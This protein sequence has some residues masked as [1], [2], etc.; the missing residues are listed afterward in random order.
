[1]LT[2]Y[3][4]V[5]A[6]VLCLVLLVAATGCKKEGDYVVYPTNTPPTVSAIPGQAADEDVAFSLDVSAFVCDAEDDVAD[7]AFTVLSGGGSFTGAVYGNTFTAAGTVSV[8]FAVADT[9]GAM[10]MGSFNVTIDPATYPPLEITTESLP[11]ATAMR[12]YSQQLAAQGGLAPYVWQIAG[13]S[14]PA[15]LTLSSS[16]LIS[17]IPLQ[18]GNH[19]FTVRCIDSKGT[20]VFRAFSIDVKHMWV[21]MPGSRPGVDYPIPRFGHAMAYDSARGVVVLFGGCDYNSQ[22]YCDT[23]EWDGTVWTDVSPYGTPGT[24][25]PTARE[26]STMA[27]DSANGVIVLFGGLDSSYN[28]CA[29]TWAWDGS[30]WTDVSPSGTPPTARCLHAMAYDSA[31]GVTV[32]FGGYDS[33]GYCGDTWIW[34]GSAWTDVSPSGTPPTARYCHAMAYDSGN[35]VTVLFGGYDGSGYCADT[36]AWDG[37][38][39]TD[40]SPAGTPPTA[41][42]YHTMAYDSANGVTV[43]FGGCDSSGYCGDTWTWD[44]SAWTDVSPSGTPG[45]DFPTAREYHT[46][47]YD[48]VRSVVVLFGGVHDWS[49]TY[50]SDTWNWDGSV[51]ENV[52]PQGWEGITVPAPRRH[53]A[54]AYDSAR[55]V[56]VLFGGGQGDDNGPEHYF[57]DTWEY[58]GIMWTNVSP[59]GSAGTDYP[60]P[61]RC[62]AM[63]Y[64]SARGVTVLF[65]GDFDEQSPIFNDTWEWDGTAWTKIT[66]SGSIP[67]VRTKHAMAYDSA[68]GVVVLFGGNDG[69]SNYSDTWEWNGYEWNQMSPSNTP[70]ARRCHA[71]VY[72]SIRGV[73]VLFGGDESGGGGPTRKNDIW[74]WDGTEW[75]DVSPSGTPGIHFPTARRHHAMAY[76]SARGVVVLFG[77]E[78]SS[79]IC[80]DTWEWNGSSWEKVPIYGGEEGVD[81]PATRRCHAMAYDS[82]R[83]VTVLFGGNPIWGDE[84]CMNDTWEY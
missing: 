70:S 2:R 75:T 43:L 35:G 32:L 34:D 73:T 79:D 62:H 17:G 28:F 67:A 54:M 68:R 71:M 80:R 63:A 12:N 44:G 10:T 78:D 20:T 52:S 33:S 57:S 69:S 21:S 42:Y 83:G 39:W 37:S 25:F 36:W 48:S 56:V 23:W 84:W 65:G 45:I 46:M 11:R 81:Y 1:M 82:A 6:L 5:G 14:M 64:D 27:Y 18:E 41:R 76:D 72:D 30:A 50:E 9:D 16:G 53:H 15:G 31:N 74:V 22:F 61:R 58:D 3:M 51:W 4:Y 19:Q 24:D 49:G 38:A 8:I 77:G 29:D 59:T 40:V 66:P 55:G 7:L 13:G 47:A 26:Y 60:E